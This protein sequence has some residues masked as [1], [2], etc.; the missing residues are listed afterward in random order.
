MS[1]PDLPETPDTPE[2]TEISCH[3]F[4]EMVTDYLDGILA[5]DV[6]TSID[7]HLAVCPGCVTVVEQWRTMIELAGQ[8]AADDV[9]ELPDPVR[10]D[11]MAAFRSALGR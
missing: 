9:E 2:T 5:P 1:E 6:V 11:L 8:L 10:D 7:E 4:V 3:Q